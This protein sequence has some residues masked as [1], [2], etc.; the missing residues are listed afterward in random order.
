MLADTVPTLSATSRLTPFVTN[1]ISGWSEKRSVNANCTNPPTSEPH[2]G[3]NVHALG[4]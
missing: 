4:T 2:L 3:R 1:S